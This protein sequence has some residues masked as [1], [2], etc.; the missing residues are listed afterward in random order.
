MA[1][2][3]QPIMIFHCFACTANSFAVDD[4]ST[5]E[6]V[7]AHKKEDVKYSEEFIRKMEEWEAKKGLT[8]KQANKQIKSIK[9]CQMKGMEL[10]TDVFL[11]VTMS[12]QE[13]RRTYHLFD[14]AFFCF[15][16]AAPFSA[17][18]DDSWC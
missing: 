15:Q 12:T 14:Y 2:V 13:V 4:S 9:S 8:G 7:N 5:S 17:I 3:E 11:F 16:L 1:F 10:T 18:S 6:D